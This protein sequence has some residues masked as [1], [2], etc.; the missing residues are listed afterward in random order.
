M[1]EKMENCPECFEP[2]KDNPYPLC[3]GSDKEEC[4]HY[5]LYVDF[6]EPPFSV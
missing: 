4:K 1:T 6:P 3:V 2:E 5:C